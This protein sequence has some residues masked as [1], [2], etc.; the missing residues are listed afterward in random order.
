MLGHILVVDDDD[1]IRYLITKFLK[2]NNYIVSSARNTLESEVYLK[3]FKFDIIILDVMMPGESG[4]DFLRRKANVLNAPVIMLTALGDVD[5]RISGLESG[6]DDY[7]AKPFEPKELLLR[8]QKILKRNQD[9]KT[10]DAFIFGEFIFDIVRGNLKRGNE[11]IRLTTNEVKLLQVLARKNGEIITREEI[12]NSFLGTN[13]RTI[14]VAIARLRA[15]IEGDTK[16][17][18]YLQTIRN[19]GYIL[20]GKLE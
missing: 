13:I 14:D 17:P 3:K 2:E 9:K 20:W 15:K 12:Q 8:I 1:R 18:E 19:Q 4:I 10:D 16:T 5:D 11:I 6:A 7:L